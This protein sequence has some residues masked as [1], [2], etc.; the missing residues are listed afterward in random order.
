MGKISNIRVANSRK[1]R[2]SESK[3]RK[4]PC[5]TNW[6]FPRQYINDYLFL[7]L[8]KISST[9]SNTDAHIQYLFYH[10]HCICL[11][12][13]IWIYAFWLTKNGNHGKSSYI[14][15]RNG[16]Q[17]NHY[18]NINEFLKF[19]FIEAYLSYLN[20]WFLQTML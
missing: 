17:S 3:T 13:N 1:N 12:M 2:H 7:L 18:I 5:L 6:N 16:F 19:F 9:N 14:E 4:F 20:C 15:R 11:C 8:L 10:I